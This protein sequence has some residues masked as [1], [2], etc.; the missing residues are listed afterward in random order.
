MWTLLR[1]S[2]VSADSMLRVMAREG[3]GL[4]GGG[5]GRAQHQAMRV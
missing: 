2:E 3:G 1:G 5:E 4:G